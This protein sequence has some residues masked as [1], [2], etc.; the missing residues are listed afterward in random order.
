MV[1]RG[2]VY[3]FSDGELGGKDGI[4][5]LENG[6]SIERFMVENTGEI[7]VFGEVDL[8]KEF[9]EFISKAEI[10]IHFFNYYGYY[11]GSF[12]PKKH[13]NSADIVL[14]QVEYY[15]D[16]NERLNIARTFVYGAVKNMLK[17]IKYYMNRGKNLIKIEADIK[18]LHAII[19]SCNSVNELMAIEGNIRNYYYQAFDIILSNPDFV[20]E[21]RSRRPPRNHL[22][23]LI[24]F[25]NSIMYTT[26][27]SQ[28]YYTHLDPRI[29]YL[30]STNFRRYTLNLDVAEIFKPIIVDRVI[31][32]VINKNIITSDD[33]ESLSEGIMLKE[34]GREAFV[35]QLEDKLE[36]TIDYK[37]I[38]ENISYKNLIKME[39]HNL[40]NY[41][42]HG[43]KYNTFTTRW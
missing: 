5:C 32:T 29:G 40:E 33:F 24:N 37:D 39:L 13:I 11:S 36:S 1:K 22:N 27:V 19:H 14:K 4:I 34:K 25:G 38:V 9:L 6:N 26:V 28:I 35:Q 18:K 3:L 7:Y 17:V 16:K 10:T 12:Y 15:L 23:T 41:L 8:N 31:F 43:E 20:F 42:I 21:Q 2:S 30:H